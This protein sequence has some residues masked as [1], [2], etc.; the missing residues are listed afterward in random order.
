MGTARLSDIPHYTYSDYIQWEGHWEIINGVAYAMTPAP[1]IRH[2]EINSRIDRQLHER[3]D[4]CLQC[5]PLLPVDWKIEDDTVVQPDNLVVCYT[6]EGDYLTKSPSLI[7]EILSPSTAQKDLGTKFEIYQKQGVRYYC[8]VDPDESLAKVYR[9][10]AGLFVKMIDASTET[11]SFDLD[12]CSFNF[13]F[14]LLW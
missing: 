11:V 7:F 1:S 9:N 10:N 8:I 5:H 14:S 4:D 12:R 3:L 13:D 2:R 6:P